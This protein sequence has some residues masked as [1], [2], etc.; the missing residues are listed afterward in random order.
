MKTIRKAK[1]MKNKTD[2]QHSRS[3]RKILEA[4]KHPFIVHLNYAFQTDGKLYLVMEYLPGG[5][6]F[7]VLDDNHHGLKEEWT[8]FY[9]SEI[10]LALGFLHKNGVIY[11]DL[12]PENILLDEKGHIRLADFGLCK[13]RIW[14][15]HIT[16]TFCGTVDYMAPEIIQKTGHNRSCDWWSLGALTYDMLKGKPPFT[17]NDN[18]AKT[19]LNICRGIIHFPYSW[20]SAS[21]DFIK[22]LLNRR[23]IDRLGG[24]KNDYRDVQ[25]HRF[26]TQCN[27]D[28]TR[29][30]KKG[31]E[32]PHKPRITHV[33]DVRN[34]DKDFTRMPAED[35]PT[36]YNIRNNENS[37]SYLVSSAHRAARNIDGFSYDPN[38]IEI[39]NRT[40]AA[41]SPIDKMSSNYNQDR[42][43][44]ILMQNQ[45]QHHQNQT[46]PQTNNFLNFDYNNASNLFHLQNKK[47]T[48]NCNNLTAQ[49]LLFS[50][51]NPPNNNNV[52]ANNAR[53]NQ[54][55]LNNLSQNNKSQLNQVNVNS[56]DVLASRANLFENGG[57]GD[58]GLMNGFGFGGGEDQGYGFGWVYFSL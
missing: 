11:R 40:I 16:N 6:L 13:E 9:A 14:D 27:L 45:Q 22:K 46:Q 55:N 51:N 28:W 21:V 15:G 54:L 42:Q 44:S 41:T 53:I 48:N 43:N 8:I 20:S 47:F 32:P 33:Y 7:K 26:F 52:I 3:E 37:S 36:S 35:S 29:V 17:E 19:E 39:Q 56:L 34:F 18:R 50:T 4:I 1:L 58:Q 25:N 49:N 57:R 2:E 10:V 30:V 24:G 23:T 12:K 5:E 31:Y 38:N